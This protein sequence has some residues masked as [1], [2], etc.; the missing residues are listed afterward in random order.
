MFSFTVAGRAFSRRT[1][2][3]FRFSALVQSTGACLV[4]ERIPATTTNTNVWWCCMHGRS[5]TVRAHICSR[6]RMLTH[7]HAH[8]RT[9]SRTHACTRTHAR[10]QVWNHLK[11]WQAK[12][13]VHSREELRHILS[14]R[15]KVPET[16]LAAMLRL[17]VLRT[18]VPGLEHFVIPIGGG[19]G[20]SDGGTGTRVGGSSSSG[21]S[22]GG[23]GGGGAGEDA[24]GAGEDPR[25]KRRRDDP[26]LDPRKRM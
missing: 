7:T 23:G 25:R 19:V 24:L 3:E 21:G 15:R 9:Y 26:P 11:D 8:A 20:G 4:R 2:C 18:P 1:R 10:A 14:Q 6:T 5:R 12:V 16:I 22:G 13:A 17:G